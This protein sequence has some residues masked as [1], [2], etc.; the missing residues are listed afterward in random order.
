MMSFTKVTNPK[1]LKEFKTVSAL[2][3][4][5]PIVIHISGSPGSGKSTLVTMLKQRVPTLYVVDTD[6][7]FEDSDPVVIQMRT[8][9]Q[10]TE[11]YVSVWKS[12][13]RESIQRHIE[14]ARNQGKK[15]IVFAGILNNM[16]GPL[17]GIVDISD[18]VY[19][20]YFLSP[21]LSTLLRRFYIRFETLKKDDEFW[22]GVVA[23]IYPIPSSEEYKKSHNEERDWHIQHGYMI[24]QDQE[25]VIANIMKIYNYN[26]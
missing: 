17:G 1:Y 7:I 25:T 18:I 2:H 21:P 24:I 4:S 5:Y 15:Y 20:K 6:E 12:A 26:E 9:D 23:G 8:L 11:S 19:Y 16:N 3:S 22:E 13:V 14:I 10:A